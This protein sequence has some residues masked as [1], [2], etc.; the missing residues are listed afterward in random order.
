MSIYRHTMTPGQDAARW[1]DGVGDLEGSPFEFVFP[2]KVEDLDGFADEVFASAAP[3]RLCGLRQNM[4]DGRIKVLAVDLHGAC[5]V[6]F[7]I[8]RS[9]TRACLF[10]H[11]C[12]NVIPRLLTN[13]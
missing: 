11:N 9:M 6:D 7:E 13:L 3:F 2:G 4:D 10:G 5:T 1:N 8:G 12:G